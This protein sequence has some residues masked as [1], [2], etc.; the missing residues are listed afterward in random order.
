MGQASDRGNSLCRGTGSLS[1]QGYWGSR[2]EILPSLRLGC[3]QVNDRRILDG[4]FAICGV[5]DS[6]FRTI[7]S[8]VDKL[9]KVM[10]KRLTLLFLDPP[11]P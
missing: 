3:L 8:S 5:P 6:K 1:E 4:M 2:R 7:C 10:T 11:L 9:D